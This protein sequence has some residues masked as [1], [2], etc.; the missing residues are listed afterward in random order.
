MA[1]NG[2]PDRCLSD[3][4]LDAEGCRGAVD[5]GPGGPSWCR[6]PGT[7]APRCRTCCRSCRSWSGTRYRGT[8]SRL[9]GPLPRDRRKLHRGVRSFV[10]AIG[11]ALVVPFPNRAI[12]RGEVFVYL[13]MHRLGHEFTMGG[14]SSRSGPRRQRP[15]ESGRPLSRSISSAT[16]PRSFSAVTRI[17]GS[18]NRQ[19][20]RFHTRDSTRECARSRRALTSITKYWCREAAVR[21][22]VLHVDHAA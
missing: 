14:R 20:V 16:S 13:S 2:R 11:R 22:V 5:R 18:S 1:P 12:V 17:C 21:F 9:R 10:R 19:L 4:A 7:R 15:V 6:G 8:R 3:G